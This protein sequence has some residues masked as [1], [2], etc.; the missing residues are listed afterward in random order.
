MNC[1]FLKDGQISALLFPQ[2]QYGVL[3]SNLRHFL[4]SCLNG[5]IGSK[6]MMNFSRPQIYLASVHFRSQKEQEKPRSV[7]HRHLLF[8]LPLAD[9]W[10]P[11]PSSFNSGRLSFT[12]YFSWHGWRCWIQVRATRLLL[13]PSPAHPSIWVVS[14]EG[15]AH[16]R[17]LKSS[18]AVA[19]GQIVPAHT[20]HRILKKTK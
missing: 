17:I 11:A 12:M 5:S 13:R 4:K 6:S 1:S 14:R 16:T 8:C 2:S 7:L 3:E 10:L 20:Q 19:H 15:P 9:P 18:V